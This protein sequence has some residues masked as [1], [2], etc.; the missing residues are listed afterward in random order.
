MFIKIPLL[1]LPVSIGSF[2]FSLFG[3]QNTFSVRKF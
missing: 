3:S 1:P 2:F